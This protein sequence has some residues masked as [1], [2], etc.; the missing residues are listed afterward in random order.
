MTVPDAKPVRLTDE[1]EE[2][3]DIPVIVNGSP[4]PIM[5]MPSMRS[6][7]SICAMRTCP[8]SSPAVRSRTLPP[9]VDAQKRHPMRQPTCEEMQTVLPCLYFITTASTQLPSASPNRYLTVP[10]IA[11]TSLRSTVGRR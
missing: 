9:M 3:D 5:T 8:I 6:P 7:V 1:A 11:D 10:S 4:M 2:T